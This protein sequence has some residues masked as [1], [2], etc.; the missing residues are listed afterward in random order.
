MCGH[1]DIQIYIAFYAKLL[2]EGKVKKNMKWKVVS[3]WW[4]GVLARRKEYVSRNEVWC[5]SFGKPVWRRVNISADVDIRSRWRNASS[6][7]WA[8]AW[9]I[10]CLNNAMI[11]SYVSYLIFIIICHI[12]I[13]ISTKSKSKWRY[14]SWGSSLL[15]LL[16]GAWRSW[17]LLQSRSWWWWRW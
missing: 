1:R 15:S 9:W 2:R 8:H 17:S 3:W 11:I 14:P 10:L 13:V 6:A 4:T 7:H 16:S 12:L 5:Q